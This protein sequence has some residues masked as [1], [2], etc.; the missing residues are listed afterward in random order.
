M[1]GDGEVSVDK[2]SAEQVS[3]LEGKKGQQI[4]TSFFLLSGDP[5]R[6]HMEVIQQ[7]S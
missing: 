1:K 3:A 6:F 5:G 2:R 7:P 4:I